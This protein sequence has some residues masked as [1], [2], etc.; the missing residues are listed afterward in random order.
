MAIFIISAAVPWMGA[1]MASRSSRFFTTWF[2]LLFQV[3]EVAPAA[4]QGLHVAVLGGFLADAIQVFFDAGEL[5]EI[6]FDEILRFGQGQFGGARQA[7]GRHAIDQAKVDGLGM[8]AHFLG[9]FFER[10]PVNGCRGGGMDVLPGAEGVQHGLVTCHVRH[11]A[12]LDLRIVQRD[13]HVAGAGN[14]AAPHAPA[15]VG[16]G[17]D[18]LQVRVG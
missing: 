15:Q 12:Q 14:K 18:V 1:L 9:H 16:A 3:G 11:D 17:G 5:L 2:T 10:D 6:C 7:K 8:A 4:Q 13:E